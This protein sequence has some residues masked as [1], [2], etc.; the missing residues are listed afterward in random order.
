M[1]VLVVIYNDGK[2]RPDTTAFA[3]IELWHSD[4]SY[5]LQPPCTTSLKL[6]T[7]PELGGD[8]LW[9]SG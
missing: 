3:K 2:R 7:S 9:S 4:V 6:N 1:K 5:E 8:T